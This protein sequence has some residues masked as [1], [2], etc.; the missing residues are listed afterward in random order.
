M[1][2][3]GLLGQGLVSAGLVNVS[4]FPFVALPPHPTVSPLSY[5]LLCILHV[6]L[7]HFNDL[8]S[9]CLPSVMSKK[10]H[11]LTL[12]SMLA[13]SDPSHVQE[14]MSPIFSSRHF[15]SL[16]NYFII[17]SLTSCCTPHKHLTALEFLASSVSPFL[18][19][20]RWSCRHFKCLSHPSCRCQN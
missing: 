3:A 15:M 19:A 11:Q 17:M 16:G 8:F 5:K 13:L 1:C 12:L 10:S 14:L 4:P 2:I 18:F 9:C 6:S 20:G 7:Y